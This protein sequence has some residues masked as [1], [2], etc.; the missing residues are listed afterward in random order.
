M[1]MRY[2]K[3][4]QCGETIVEV[5]IAGAVISFGLVNAYVF[6]HH[7]TQTITDSQEHSLAEKYVETQLEY[8][9]K[10][11]GTTLSNV[12]YDTSGVQQNS[13]STNCRMTPYG[14]GTQPSYV[15]KIVKPSVSGAYSVTA[16]WDSVYGKGQ[17]TVSMLYRPV[18]P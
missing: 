3:L 11:N 10:N 1:N 18:A 16:T 7:S 9:R 4:G 14:P 17:S 12:C 5:I 8:I 13:S 2:K 6:S 15:M